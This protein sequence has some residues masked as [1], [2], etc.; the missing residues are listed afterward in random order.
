[1]PRTISGTVP[2]MACSTPR[3]QS[4]RLNIMCEKIDHFKRYDLGSEMSD[5]Q[6]EDLHRGR[7]FTMRW[8]RQGRVQTVVRPHSLYEMM[9]SEGV[10]LE[11]KEYRH[12]RHA[13]SK[14]ISYHRSGRHTGEKLRWRR[15][16]TLREHRHWS[17]RP[18]L[19]PEMWYRLIDRMNNLLFEK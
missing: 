2:P 3:V 6:T 12:M 11:P 13:L 4:R 18:I 19:R 1:A 9:R 16:P 15:L 5:W 8:R 17:N 7:P 10:R 14:A